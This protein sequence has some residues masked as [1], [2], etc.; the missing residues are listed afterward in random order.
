MREKQLPLI[1]PASDHP[2]ERELEVISM[3]IENTPTICEYV[4]QDLN[5]GK[6]IKSRPELAA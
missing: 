6:I 4:L 3:I 2:Q 1:E 5:K